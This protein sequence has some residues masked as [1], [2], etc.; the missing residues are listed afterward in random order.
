MFSGVLTTLLT[1][2]DPC[3]I[4]EDLFAALADWQ[5]AE[6]AAGLVTGAIAGEGST[7]SAAERYRLT[8]I[9]VEIAGGRVPVLAATGT[10]CTSTT[11]ELTR[12]AKTAGASAAILVAP[13]YNK[14]TQEGLFRHFEAV[15]HA[16]DL[17]LIVENAP[18]RTNLSITPATLERLG[19]LPS[20][21]AVI[22]GACDQQLL[23]DN[24][25]AC[26]D[27]LARL[28]PREC[29]PT[30]FD[31]GTRG[32]LSLAANIAPSLCREAWDANIGW[33]GG[34]EPAVARLRLLYR[35]LDMEPEPIAAKYAVSLLWPDFDPRPRLP[36]TAARDDTAAMMRV[37]LA[38][39]AGKLDA[40]PP[41]AARPL[42]GD[43]PAA[44]I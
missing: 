12:A 16:V 37:A 32:C 38:R 25:A 19:T 3:E 33:A 14:P 41:D 15:A 31:R 43:L 30:A 34:D 11:I 36:L 2:F 42:A 22:D 21:V 8:R 18:A 44:F 7:L 5:I 40:M 20:V 23:F 29:A 6:G 4:D 9:A 13:Y 39:L 24:A 28:A 27:R 35:A 1:P 10:N 17:P 26:G